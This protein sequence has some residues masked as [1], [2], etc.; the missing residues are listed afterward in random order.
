MHRE[1]DVMHRD[2]S[3]ENIFL[4]AAPFLRRPHGDGDDDDVPA[5]E[6]VCSIH[7]GDAVA[8]KLG[9]FASCV[10]FGPGQVRSWSCVRPLAWSNRAVCVWS[11]GPVGP[12]CMRPLAWYTSVVVC[13]ATCLVH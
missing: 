8:V 11:L 2:V 7:G 4:A 13:A 6:A 12:L 5:D 9:G 10:F 1:K 3:L